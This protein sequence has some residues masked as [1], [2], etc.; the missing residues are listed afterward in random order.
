MT[1]VC[2]AASTNDPQLQSHTTAYG[3]HI[4]AILDVPVQAICSNCST[5][6]LRMGFTYHGGEASGPDAIRELLFTS[7]GTSPLYTPAAQVVFLT[8]TALLQLVPGTLVF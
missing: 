6:T 8:S 4:E 1:V 5:S 2:L 3:T 7:A